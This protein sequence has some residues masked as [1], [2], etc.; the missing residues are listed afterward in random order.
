VVVIYRGRAAVTG[1]E[2]VLFC[3]GVD[4]DRAIDGG[5]AIVDKRGVVADGGDWA[6]GRGDGIRVLQLGGDGN[7]TSWGPRGEAAATVVAKISKGV[8][9]GL[10]ALDG[11]GVIGGKRADTCAGLLERETG[12]RTSVQISEDGVVLRAERRSLEAPLTEDKPDKY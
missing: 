11:G 1:R 9:G 8:T 6:V 10:D 7:P 3:G 2:P 4:V 5:A 12:V